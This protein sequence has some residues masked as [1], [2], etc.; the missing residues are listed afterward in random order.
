[1]NESNIGT[2]IKDT[3]PTDKKRSVNSYDRARNNL[4]IIIVLSLVN[5]G[6]LFFGGDS[7]YVFCASIPYVITDLAMYFC[8][9]YPLEYYGLAEG[10]VLDFYGNEVFAV[11]IML[12]VICI[13]AYAL[14]YILSKKRVGWMI[15]ALVFFACDTVFM[16]YW[17]GINLNNALDILA[18]GWILVSMVLGLVYYYK[19]KKQNET[20][21]PIDDEPTFEE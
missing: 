12:A 9:K 14:C 4:L 2:E 5:I 1:M 21:I 17:W 11:L 18:H 20:E 19:E 3:L 6:I 8:G 13:A 16:L 10:E 15:F 7:Y